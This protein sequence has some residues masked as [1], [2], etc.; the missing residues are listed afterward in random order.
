[1]K[2][3]SKDEKPAQTSMLRNIVHACVYFQIPQVVW[4]MLKVSW[5]ILFSR[6][7]CWKLTPLSKAIIW[8]I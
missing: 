5:E 2:F 1:M 3:V 7:L 6:G 8:P 4:H